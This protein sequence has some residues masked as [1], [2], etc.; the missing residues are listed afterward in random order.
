MGICVQ[1]LIKMWKS[2]RTYYANYI[3]S[4]VSVVGSRYSPIFPNSSIKARQRLYL[5]RKSDV[6]LHLI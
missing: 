6:F 2:K 4:I 5:A 1:K 3:C